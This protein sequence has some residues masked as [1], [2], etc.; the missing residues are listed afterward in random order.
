MVS[1]VERS[2]LKRCCVWKNTCQSSQLWE[3]QPERETLNPRLLVLVFPFWSHSWMVL[4]LL[5]PYP[6]FFYPTKHKLLLQGNRKRTYSW[7]MLPAE[8]VGLHPRGLRHKPVTKDEAMVHLQPASIGKQRQG[9]MTEFW[10]P[11]RLWPKPW[12]TEGYPWGL[13]LPARFLFSYK[14]FSKWHLLLYWA[15]STSEVRLEERS[16][17]CRLREIFSRFGIKSSYHGIWAAVAR[18]A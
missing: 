5:H 16:Q 3:Q 11:S 7:T 4:S 9:K 2:S 1:E 15:A 18:Q 17:W 8:C 6:V 13:Q 14:A 12:P 10:E